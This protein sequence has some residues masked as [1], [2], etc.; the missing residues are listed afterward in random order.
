M[1]AQPA[2]V[3][4]DEVF[5]GQVLEATLDEPRSKR[6]PH[7]GARIPAQPGEL[8]LSILARRDD[9]LGARLFPTVAAL[10]MRPQLPIAD[11]AHRRQIGMQIAAST[12]SLDLRDE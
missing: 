6:R 3:F 11:G 9:G 12:Q 7:V 2:G 8:S 1:L 4:R 5:F 10:E